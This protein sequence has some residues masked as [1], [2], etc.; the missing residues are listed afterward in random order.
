MSSDGAAWPFGKDV[1]IKMS[2]GRAAPR[3]ARH[4]AH[5]KM[6]QKNLQSSLPKKTISNAFLAELKE[7]ALLIGTNWY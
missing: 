1:A 7:R 5:K 4:R 2:I 6:R 3:E